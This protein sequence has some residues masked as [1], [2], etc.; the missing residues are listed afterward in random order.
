MPSVADVSEP[1]IA[2]SLIPMPTITYLTPDC[3]STSRSKRVRPACP[4]TAPNRPPAASLGLSFNSRFPM[5]PSFRTPNSAF[6][7]E[8]FCNRKLRVRRSVPG[9]GNVVRLQGQNVQRFHLGALGKE[10][11]DRQIRQ[12]CYLQRD[13]V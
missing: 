4:R 1:G 5:M 11:T 6:P 12:S 8:L 3:A 13:R 7:P 10:Q 9:L 2:M